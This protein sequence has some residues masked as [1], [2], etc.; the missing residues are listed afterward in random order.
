MAGSVQMIDSAMA[1]LSRAT[2]RLE[3]SAA[4]IARLPDLGV[5]SGDEVNLS[6]E[7]VNLLFAKRSYE[8]NLKAIETA[9]EIRDHAI[10]VLG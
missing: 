4:R 3:K 9:N 6:E 10:D 1:G 7:I 2:K 5:K 8:A